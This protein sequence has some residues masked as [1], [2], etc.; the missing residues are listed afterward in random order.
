ML[1]FTKKRIKRL[2]LNIKNEYN[3][4]YFQRIDKIVDF[5]HNHKRNEKEIFLEMKLDD[6]RRIVIRHY[7]HAVVVE[8][9]KDFSYYIYKKQNKSMYEL[10]H[11]QLT[12]PWMS[13]YFGDKVQAVDYVFKIAEEYNKIYENGFVSSEINFSSGELIFTNYFS[14]L[15][16]NDY[17]FDLPE[18]LKYKDK[19]SINE[20][21]GQQNCMRKLSNNHNLGYAQLSNT[22]CS[23][24][25]VSDNK[26]IIASDFL[27][28]YDKEKDIETE[29]KPPKEY[30]YL[31]SISCEVWR[32]EFMDKKDLER[33]N[34][35]DM[36]ML[37]ENVK[38]NINPGK[39]QVKN[40]HHFISDNEALKN[41]NIPVWVEITKI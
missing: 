11:I 5:I 22:T 15:K 3:A 12:T 10:R 33:S 34:N 13:K 20:S 18:G 25:K 17:A 8:Q 28:Y 41:S 1:Y 14:N 38:V 27:Y 21:L 31:G 26:I 30:Q 35:F 2:L 39:Y 6:Y 19:Y 32:L 37:E 16:G 7:K 40:Y 29:I 23:I 4:K 24:Y 36:G 9:D